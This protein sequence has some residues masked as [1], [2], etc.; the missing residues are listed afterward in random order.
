VVRE[1][2]RNIEVPQPIEQLASGLG[3]SRR[4]IERQFRLLLDETPMKT[5][6]N[7]RLDH[8]RR[9]FTDT[10]M[11]VAEVAT[12]CGFMSSTHFSRCYRERFGTSP[13]AYRFKP[14]R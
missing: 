9:L 11:S 8:A 2:Q 12:A 1:M 10:D 3:Y 4:Q 13:S 7:I 5:Y 6:R 14:R